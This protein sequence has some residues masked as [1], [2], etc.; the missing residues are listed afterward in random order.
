M[1][2]GIV[3]CFNTFGFHICVTPNRIS[4]VKSWKWNLASVFAV[5]CSQLQKG[6]SLHHESWW[7]VS[8]FFLLLPSPHVPLSWPCPANGR[9]EQVKTGTWAGGRDHCSPRLSFPLSWIPTLRLGLGTN[10]PISHIS[11]YQ[12]ALHTWAVSWRFLAATGAVSS[13]WSCVSKVPVTPRGPLM[14]LTQLPKCPQCVFTSGC[15]P[16]C[17]SQ[18]CE[19]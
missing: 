3:F 10:P 7:G 2:L 9:W 4:K 16:T 6:T 5:L 13:H 15:F 19:E 11:L 14:H 12:T 1:L 8:A 18:L 17:H